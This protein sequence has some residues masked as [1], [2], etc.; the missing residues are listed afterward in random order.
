[1]R[2]ETPF[3][4]RWGWTDPDFYF[5]LPPGAVGAALRSPGCDVQSFAPTSSTQEV[6]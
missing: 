2:K 3:A 4:E 6:R 5:T 1:M